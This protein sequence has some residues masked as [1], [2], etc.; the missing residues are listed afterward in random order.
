MNK[1]LRNK[2][3]IIVALLIV[4][5]ASFTAFG[6]GAKTLRADTSLSV[7]PYVP[8]SA[9]ETFSPNSPKESYFE[10]GLFVI[11]DEATSLFVSDGIRKPEKK[12]NFVSLGTIRN[13][14]SDYLLLS[15]N[16]S[17]YM[18]SKTDYTSTA[19]I[20]SVENKNIGTT[21]DYN[22]EFLVTGTNRKVIIYTL[23]GNVAIFASE[24]TTNTD[25]SPVAINPRG[26]VF[27]VNDNGG[28]CIK[29]TGEDNIEQIF[30]YTPKKIIANDTVAYFI[31][32]S[33]KICKYTI[34]E[35]NVT[36][37]NTLEKHKPFQLGNV[38]NPTGISFKGENLLITTA[39]SQEVTNS[40][41]AVQEFKVNGNTLEFTGF[42]VASG[43]TAYNRTSFTAKEVSVYENNIAVLDDTKLTLSVNGEFSNLFLNDLNDSSFSSNKVEVGNNTLLL[44]EKASPAYKLLSIN[45]FTE[46]TS[47][48]LNGDYLSDVC[49]QN[50]KF[51]I[52]TLNTYQNG[53]ATLY[54]LS[55]DGSIS[56]ILNLTG[57]YN[58]APYP[59]ISV[60]TN[61]N[62]Y[63]LNTKENCIEKYD[64][65]LQKS[66][67]TT[68]NGVG[69]IEMQTDL[70]GKIYALY[71][72]SLFVTSGESQESL[73]LAL[74]P[75]DFAL[76]F[77]SKKAYFLFNGEETVYATEGAKNANTVDLLT[78]ESYVVTNTSANIDNLNLV[79]ATSGIALYEVDASSQVMAYKGIRYG[80]GENYYLSCN[81]TISGGS[82]LSEKTYSLLIGEKIVFALTSL[83]T[84]VTD[85][86]LT[87]IPAKDVFVTT[88]VNAY[89]IPIL[90]V[91][92]EHVLKDS[93]RLKTGD[94]IKATHVANLLDRDF[95]YAKI[96][97]TTFGYVP[98]NFTAPILSKDALTESYKI[99]KIKQADVF[100]D[101]QLTNKITTL[102]ENTEIRFVSEE[103][104]IAEIMFSTE[105]G[106]VTAYINAENIKKV[107]STAL[108][109]ALVVFSAGLVLF[110]TSLYL[111]LRK[112]NG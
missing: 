46:I 24:I 78:P 103:N 96:T 26:D 1:L 93:V 7:Y 51:Y 21:F 22:G 99:K 37:L 100:S 105:S 5:L 17:I 3:Y 25:N 55:E 92:G 95:Y 112:R 110:A 72:N 57:V 66:I 70:N 77:S 29:K 102:E 49:Y 36:E 86:L 84:D 89:Y 41:S 6:L 27:F 19:I 38:L 40:F 108:K 28:F 74:T 106:Y 31:D 20:D 111:I 85:S 56:E 54:T 81:F 73:S 9:L 53:N 23:S 48:S 82:S 71:D 11:N 75:K 4:A 60:D 61:N 8:S 45:G 68:L 97:E 30:G 42:A 50:G 35:N 67:L 98:V 16:G 63:V 62:V 109:T 59:L 107:P 2:L 13:F 90:T 10:D 14:N 80:E 79:S 15:E 34:S 18:F 83:L 47:G 52:L 104:G 64:S 32:D 44:T 88:D 65:S 69:A 94:L 101:K 39:E 87:E 76:S 12:A 43:K 58:G 91:N 33:G